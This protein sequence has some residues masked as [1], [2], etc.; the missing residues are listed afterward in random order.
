LYR[1]YLALPLIAAFTAGFGLLGIVC[2]VLRMSRA[3]H[4]LARTWGRVIL[5]TLGIDVTVTG[6][7]HCPPGP[8]VYAANHVSVVDTPIVFGYVPAEFKILHKRSLYFIPIVGQYLYVTGH[9]GIHRGSGFRAR[10]GLAQAA[11]RIRGGTSLVV[12]PE[13][14]RQKGEGGVAGFKRGSFVL[15]L[16]AGVP[17]A[18]LSI[19]GVKQLSFGA[20]RMRAGQVRMVFHPPVTTAGRGPEQAAALAEEVRRIVVAGCEAA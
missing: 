6:A 3:V 13:G 9:I 12:F 10:R 4:R 20:M 15:A 14:T 8:A 1:G 11:A 17:V 5:W 7:E 16:E 18:P 2:G 19:I